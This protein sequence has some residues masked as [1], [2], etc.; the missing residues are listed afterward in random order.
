VT[1][2]EAF[3]KVVGLQFGARRIQGGCAS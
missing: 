1:I 3:A 2:D